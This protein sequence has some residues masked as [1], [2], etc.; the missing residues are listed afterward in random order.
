MAFPLGQQE[1][2]AP[3]RAAFRIRW[4]HIKDRAVPF[5]KTRW[6]AEAVLLLAYCLRS[7]V[8][9]QGFYIISYALGIGLLTL[10]VGFLTPLNVESLQNDHMPL[11]PTQR[12]EFKPFIRRLSEFQFWYRSFSATLLSIVATFFPMLDVPVFWPIL[13]IYF[14]LLFVLQMK[15]R[16]RHMVQHKY[17]PF[18]TGKKTYNQP[19]ADR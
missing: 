6:T 12:G 13:L 19:G 9:L 15:D 2:L 16:I 3:I 7:F 14:I 1:R 18:T 5:T 17:V 10:F 8:W 11:L 4:Q